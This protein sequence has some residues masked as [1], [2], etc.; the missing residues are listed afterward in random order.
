MLAINAEMQFPKDGGYELRTELGDQ[1]VTVAFRVH[2][3]AQQA[4]NSG[5]ATSIDLPP[6]L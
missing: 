2:F 5:S 6:G 3:P 4:G 1:V